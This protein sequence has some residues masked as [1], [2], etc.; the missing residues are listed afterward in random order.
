MTLGQLKKAPCDNDSDIFTFDN[1]RERN[2]KNWDTLQGQ[3]NLDPLHFHAI[4]SLKCSRNARTH[5]SKSI[6]ET[7]V[8]LRRQASVDGI[9]FTFLEN[10]KCCTE[11]I[12]LTI[13]CSVI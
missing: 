10:G 2:K 12:K 9:I 13:Q 11:R 5:L 4:K 7:I 8:I 3:F 1:E 6:D